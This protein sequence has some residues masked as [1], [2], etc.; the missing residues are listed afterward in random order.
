MDKHCRRIPSLPICSICSHLAVPWA[1]VALVGDAA[2]GVTPNLGQGCNAALETVAVLDTVRAA[3][4]WRW[5]TTC[6]CCQAGC[7]HT[8]VHSAAVVTMSCWSQMH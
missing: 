2:H 7:E 6:S 8:N 3:R 4:L 5:L 1:G